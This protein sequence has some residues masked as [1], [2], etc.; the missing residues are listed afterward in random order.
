LGISETEALKR[1]AEGK[2]VFNGKP[3][4]LFPAL[5]DNYRRSLGDGLAIQTMLS[6][7][8]GE[9]RA[10]F[11]FCEAMS[12][13][14][15]GHEIIQPGNPKLN[16]RR[17]R[18]GKLPLLETRVLTVTVPGRKAS[19]NGA[20]IADRASPRQ[21]LRRGHPRNYQ[22]GTRLWIP[23]TVVGDASRGSVRKTYRLQ[24]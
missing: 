16:E 1:V 20:G 4:I 18:S 12:C 21:H 23:S 2:P 6:D 14:N 3:A 22:N 9:I 10:L 7:I 15:V 8:R 11:E 5:A 24:A 13:S 19:G 17:V